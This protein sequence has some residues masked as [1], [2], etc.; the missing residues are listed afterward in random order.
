M[1]TKKQVN[2]VPEGF[3]D[4]TKTEV[5]V[6]AFEVS[7]PP[8]SESDEERRV[9]H[10]NRSCD[11]VVAHLRILR[12]IYHDGAVQGMFDTAIEHTITAHMWAVRAVK[13]R[14]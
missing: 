3:I 9:R 2:E 10:L 6:A 11:A 4:T 7:P 13:H 8:A 12:D 1:A 5:I 14:G